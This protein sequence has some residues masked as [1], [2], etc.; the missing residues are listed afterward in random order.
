M[1]IGRHFDSIPIMAYAANVRRQA[2]ESAGPVYG[3]ILGIG[4]QPPP[5]PH[6]TEPAD[7]T[8][9]PGL[10]NLRNTCYLNSILQYLYTVTPIRELVLNYDPA[11]AGLSDELA[12]QN[13]EVYLGRECEYSCTAALT[14]PSCSY[15][16]SY[17]RAPA[18]IPGAWIGQHKVCEAA[19]TPGQRGLAVS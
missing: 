7:L 12:N 11:Q 16:R 3:E 5:A 6:E 19:A 9:P 1:A 14:S 15:H 17:T 2:V 4:N 18:A 8:L 10:D 13:E